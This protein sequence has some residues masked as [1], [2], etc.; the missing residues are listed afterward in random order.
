MGKPQP[1]TRI[2]RCRCHYSSVHHE[3]CHAT[4]RSCDHSPACKLLCLV[5]TPTVNLFRVRDGI[6]NMAFLVLKE[7][8]RR[9]EEGEPEE[10]EEE[11]IETDYC[12]P[13][14]RHK[15]AWIGVVF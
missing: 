10:E 8:L 7:P 5:S 14:L 12:R 13:F 15:G 4:P 11:E 9:K 2:G 6:A 1:A 3:C